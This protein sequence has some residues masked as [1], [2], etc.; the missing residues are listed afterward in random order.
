MCFRPAVRQQ[1]PILQRGYTLVELSLVVLILGIMAATV[2][3]N[4]ISPDPGRL[5]LAAQEYADAMRFARSEAMRLRVPFGFSQDSAS[6]RIRVFRAATNAEPWTETYN[7]YHPLNK[8]IY[9]IRI[10]QHPF[11]GADTAI[12]LSQYRGTCNKVD[13]VYFDADGVPRCLDPQTVLL[14]R[15][16]ITL[17]AGDQQRVVSLEPIPG[18]VTIQ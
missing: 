17:E 14:E 4:F 6:K 1:N 5:H 16:D 8:K 12:A 2:I 11:A 15:Y 10:D 9:D 3:P 7:V 13:S 18:Q